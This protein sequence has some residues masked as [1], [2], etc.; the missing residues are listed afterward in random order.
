MGI[1]DVIDSLRYPSYNCVRV[2]KGTYS[3]GNGMGG[4]TPIYCSWKV[5]KGEVTTHKLKT[6]RV[7][8]GDHDRTISRLGTFVVYPKINTALISRPWPD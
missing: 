6:I 3:I 5:I 7:R 1:H 8:N 4:G 2:N